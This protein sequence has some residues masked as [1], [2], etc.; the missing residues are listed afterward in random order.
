[1]PYPI[2][3]RLEKIAQLE[4]IEIAQVKALNQF[5]NTLNEDKEGLRACWT[6]PLF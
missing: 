5:L 2:M 4:A 6:V 1:M 3:V